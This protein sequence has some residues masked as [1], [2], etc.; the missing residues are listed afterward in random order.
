MCALD[1]ASSSRSMPSWAAFCD[2]VSGE[3]AGVIDRED[4][5]MEEIAGNSGAQRA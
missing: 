2:L 1:I 3:L 5:T 4:I